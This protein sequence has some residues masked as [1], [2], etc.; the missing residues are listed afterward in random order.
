M[1]KIFSMHAMMQS[2]LKIA[3]HIATCVPYPI[4]TASAFKSKVLASFSLQHLY[5]YKASYAEY[6]AIAS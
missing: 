3:V 4:A 2:A 5:S 6:V 1:H